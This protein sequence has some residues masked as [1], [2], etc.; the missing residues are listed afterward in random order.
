MHFSLHSACYTLFLAITA[1]LSSCT[2]YQLGSAK[3][4]ELINIQSIYIPMIEN[5]TQEIKLAPQATNSLTRFINNDG[6][7]Q[8]SSAAQSDATLRVVIEK[9]DYREFRSSRLDT[10]RAEELTAN[11][12]ATWRLTDN[13]SNILISGRSNG[14]TRFFVDDNQRLSRDNALHDAIQS[15][16]RKITSRISNGF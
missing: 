2:G 13:Q 3:P 15:L 9:I 4:A 1:C 14:E 16:S 10:L 8:V 6:T 7:F 5:K 11:I 12:V